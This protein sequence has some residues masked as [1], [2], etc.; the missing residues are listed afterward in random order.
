[1][2]RY[3]QTIFLLTAALMMVP[4]CGTPADSAPFTLV[5]LP[6]TQNYSE[7]FPETFHAQTR[8]VRQNARKEN[9]VFVT[10]VGD[11]VQHGG[12]VASE[13]EVANA[14]MSALDGVVPWAVTIGNHDYDDLAKDQSP[15]FAKYFGPKR[16]AGR[17][18]YGG[19]SDDGQCSYQ[20]FEG[21][22][23]RFLILHL[24]FM[25]KDEALAW[26]EAVL[27]KHPDLPTIVTTHAYL[28]PRR[29][30][31]GM[32]PSI[33]RPGHNGPQEIRDKLI[34]KHPQI[35]L[36]LSGHVNAPVPTYHMDTNE[37]GGKVIAFVA[38]FQFLPDGGQGW[39]VLLTFD[40][41]KDL[42]RVRAY[43]PV[44]KKYMTEPGSQFTL[45]YSVVTRRTAAK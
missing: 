18:W 40:P 21:G 43:S 25:V 24:P 2:R 45:P 12:D 32:Y 11:I 28:D 20:F 17:P 4:A 22:A 3:W 30:P 34:R 37:A 15:T 10:H 38:N 14:A 1:M 5:M 16:F 23:K 19:G 6:D 27:A 36:V 7:K 42:I 8:W 35:F 9:V 39:L 26:A 44:L 29:G 33:S 41:A 31:D 13:W